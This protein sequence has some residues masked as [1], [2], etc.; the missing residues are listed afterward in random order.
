M[1]DTPYVPPK[2]WT[3]QKANGGRFA[4]INT[5]EELRAMPWSEQ[6]PLRCASSSAAGQATH[7]SLLVYLLAGLPVCLPA[8]RPASLPAGL[9]VSLVRLLSLPACVSILSLLFCLL[10]ALIA[11]L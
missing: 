7:L 6:A 10:I 9:P 11:G 2:V 3:W 1:P 8:C 4:N 5:L